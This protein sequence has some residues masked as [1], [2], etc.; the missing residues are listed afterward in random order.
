M[1][2]T[3]NLCHVDRADDSADNRVIVL[4]VV[5]FKKTQDR[6]KT[7]SDRQEALEAMV[8]VFPSVDWVLI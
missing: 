1:K 8:S 4:K 5:L 6:P 2:P 7:D 3:K